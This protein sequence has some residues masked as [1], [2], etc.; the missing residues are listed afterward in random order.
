[1]D[2]D[3]LLVQ[4]MRAGDEQAIE[5]FVKKYYPAILAYCRLHIGDPGDAQDLT[6]ETFLRFFRTLSGYRHY[7][8]A[9]NYLYTIATNACKDYYKKRRDIPV[10]H[11]PERPDL[12][13]QQTE[14]GIDLAR[15]F[16][17]LPDALYETAVLYFLQEQRQT[18]IA[19]ILGISLP[20][21]KYRIRKAREYFEAYFS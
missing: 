4:K 14:D 9:A 21:V 1:M 2:R 17:G 12:K 10:E 18:D 5:A 20:L 3:F 15:A 7:K 6:Q 19:R 13:L 16:S 8:K 11:L